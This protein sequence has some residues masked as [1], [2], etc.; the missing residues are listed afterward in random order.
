MKHDGVWLGCQIES[1]ARSDDRQGWNI[2]VWILTYSWR[3]TGL[4]T[5]KPMF[6]VEDFDGERAIADLAV[7]PREYYDKG[8]GGKRRVHFEERGA[9]MRDILWT[10]HRYLQH[11][12]L[13]ADKT[14]SMARFSS[15]SQS[16]IRTSIISK[17]TSHRSMNLSSWGVLTMKST[18]FR[19]SRSKRFGSPSRMRMG[20]L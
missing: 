15:P 7:Y 10:G 20:S 3:G 18:C 8:D 9:T 1:V 16:S 14:R 19:R 12:G 4:R 13:R 11:N 5:S 6:V 17:L 2:W